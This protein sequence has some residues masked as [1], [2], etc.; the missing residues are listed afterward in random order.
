MAALVIV[1]VVFAALYVPLYR[2]H[3][4]YLRANPK[5]RGQRRPRAQAKAPYDPNRP[6]GRD[7]PSA[8]VMSTFGPNGRRHH[9]H[10]G[11]R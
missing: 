2:W 1:A 9:H 4:R 11:G 10:H 7:Y 8:A 3:G 5:L 6:M